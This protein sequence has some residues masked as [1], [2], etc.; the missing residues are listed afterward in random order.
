LVRLGSER[1]FERENLTTPPDLAAFQQTAHADGDS[2]VLLGVDDVIA[3]ALRLQPGLRPE[4]TDIVA[5]LRARG[6]SLAII[7]G[8]AEEPTRKL[9]NDLGISV[10]FPNTLP[11]NK[12]AIIRNL[13][14][15]GRSVCFVGDGINDGVA[16]KQAQVSVSLAGATTVA[17]DV[18]QVILMDRG[19]R[20]LP[21]L[22]NA[23]DNFTANTQA[24]LRMA[25]IPGFILIGGVYT[26]GWGIG[27]S[28]VVWIASLLAGI[29]IAFAPLRRQRTQ[30]IAGRGTSRSTYTLPAG[31]APSSESVDA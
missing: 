1:F 20:H 13:Q 14:Q 28:Y 9:A 6:M 10:Y 24:G 4:V 18:A 26:L 5:E 12:A 15:Q 25:V 27:A 7:S 29:G 17:T 31:P 22:F 16:L 21:N 23:A 2:L 8:D 3:G 11:D 19:L 30:V